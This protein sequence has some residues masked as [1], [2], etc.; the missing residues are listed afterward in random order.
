MMNDQSSQK[1]TVM[2]DNEVH[3]KS[4]YFFLKKQNIS[5]TVVHPG[6]EPEAFQITFEASP[7]TIELINDL[8][9][10]WNMKESER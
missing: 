2:L 7:D 9:D 1:I 5:A 10:R 8:F 3:A 6:A 4:L